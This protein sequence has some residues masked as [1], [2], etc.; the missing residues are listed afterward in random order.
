M[1]DIMPYSFNGVTDYPDQRAVAIPGQSQGVYI[2][3]HPDVVDETAAKI[4]RWFYD[5][6]EVQIVDVGTSDKRGLGFIIIEWLECG[7]DPLFLA[8]LRDEET[9]ADYTVYGRNL[10]G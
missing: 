8:I 3:L 6:D 2:M 1:A 5:R 7:V 10:E 4:E 9:V